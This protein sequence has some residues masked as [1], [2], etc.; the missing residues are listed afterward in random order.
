MKKLWFLIVWLL[1]PLNV[2][3]QTEIATGFEKNVL[4]DFAIIIKYVRINSVLLIIVLFLLF[5]LLK[6]TKSEK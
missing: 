5:I 6:R 4:K 1:F 2:F 3:A